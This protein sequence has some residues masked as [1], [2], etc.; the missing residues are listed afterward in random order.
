MFGINVLLLTGIVLV[1]VYFF[2]SAIRIVREYERA[3]VFRLGHLLGGKGPGLVLIIPFV[4]SAVRVSLRVITYDVPPQEVITRDNVTCKVNAVV[5]Y[6]VVDPA[7]AIVNVENFH[8]A[9]AQLAQTTLRSVVGQADFDQILVER[10]QLNQRIQQIL[11]EATDRWG[12]K[13]SAVELKD[14]IVPEGL[15][16]AI[17]RQAEAE[18][19]R[20]ALIIQSEGEFQ[21]AERISQAAA[22]LNREPGGLT[23]RIVRLLP[24]IAAR[25]GSLIAFPI[26]VELGALLGSV[27]PG[28]AGAGRMLPARDAVDGA[29]PN[30][31]QPAAGTEAAGDA[32]GREGH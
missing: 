29:G 10:E 18:R 12:I 21:A 32:A 4:D 1:V 16:Q 31:L 28:G 11:D 15:L 23:L 17:A 6:R 19:Q 2:S 13:V 14:V 7:L 22:V 3:V 30:G 25:P 20:R 5:Y 27:L 9:T 26:P 24:E 8:Q